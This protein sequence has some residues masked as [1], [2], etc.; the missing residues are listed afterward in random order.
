MQEEIIF[1]LPLTLI[2]S[3]SWPSADG[4]K[5]KKIEEFLNEEKFTMPTNGFSFASSKKSAFVLAI[6]VSQT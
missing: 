6:D 2:T 4:K 1:T 3:L 5:E